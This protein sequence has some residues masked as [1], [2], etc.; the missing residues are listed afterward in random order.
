MLDRYTEKQSIKANMKKKVLRVVSCAALGMAIAL[1]LVIVIGGATFAVTYV[2]SHIIVQLMQW[3]LSHD[4][5]D[6][7]GL[8][9]IICLMGALIGAFVGWTND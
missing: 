8:A 4:Q 2:G 9:C 3:G 7:C 5:V 6:V 1:A